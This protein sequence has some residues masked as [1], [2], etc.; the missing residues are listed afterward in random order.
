[1][2]VINIGPSDVLMKSRIV[3]TD[4]R[5]LDGE[6]NLRDALGRRRIVPQD[7]PDRAG[8]GFPHEH[9]DLAIAVIVA[10]GCAP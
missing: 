8:I 7:G 9:V 6:R 4:S 10:P 3:Q 1:M 2:V 5:A